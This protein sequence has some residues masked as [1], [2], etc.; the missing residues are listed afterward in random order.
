MPYGCSPQWE[1]RQLCELHPTPGAAAL[2]SVALIIFCCTAGRS[3]GWFSVSQKNNTWNH[4]HRLHL[5]F[6]QAFFKGC[7]FHFPNLIRKLSSCSYFFKKK[8]KTFRLKKKFLWKFKHFTNKIAFLN[9]CV[10]F[11]AS[12][13]IYLFKKF[14]IGY[15]KDEYNSCNMLIKYKCLMSFQVLLL[16]TVIL[17]F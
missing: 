14:Q 13:I 4:C 7:V 3:M 11:P 1:V 16:L 12:Y 6:I 9:V 15:R 5:D 8:N 17:S 10:L 2:G